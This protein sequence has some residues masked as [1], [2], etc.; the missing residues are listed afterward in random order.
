MNF[1]D[2]DGDNDLDLVIAGNNCFTGVETN[3]YRNDNCQQSNVID[4]QHA[5]SSF[6]W[7]DGIEYTTNNNTASMTYTNA[8]G[9]DSVVVLHLTIGDYSLIPDVAALPNI[10]A[11]CEITSLT[12]PTAMFNCSGAVTATTNQSFP[13]TLQDTTEVTWTYT[14]N[15]GVEITQTQLVIIHDMTAPVPDLESLPVYTSPC[16]IVA[17]PVIPTATDNCGGTITGTTTDLP[18]GNAGT[19]TITWT[20]TDANGNSSIQTQDIVYTGSA[21]C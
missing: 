5:C 10:T 7:I 14:G 4:V 6:T 16:V 9:C 2:I 20:F 11:E 12:P 1:G 8:A 17:V 19:T 13:I 15:N 3:L 21:C 18:V